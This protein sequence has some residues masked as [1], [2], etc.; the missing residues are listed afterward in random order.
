MTDQAA[1]T[2]IMVHRARPR[3]AVATAKAL[4]DQGVPL[5]LVIVDNGSSSRDVAT[6]RTEIPGAEVIELGSNTGFG[7]AANIGLRRWLNEGPGADDWAVVCPHDAVVEPHCLERLLSAARARP[8]AG[9]ASA[10]YGDVGQYG[11]FGDR[12]LPAVN[13]WFGPILETSERCLGWENADHPHGTLMILR[14]QCLDDIGLFD[15]R[16]F[17]YCEEAEL[18]LRA[19]RAGWQ[20]GVVWGAVVRN[21]GMTSER[22]VPEYLMMRNSLMLQRDHFGTRHATVLFC[23]YLFHTVRGL[24]YPSRR[25]LY[26]HTRGRLLAMADFAR[27]RSGPAPAALTGANRSTMSSHRA[28]TTLSSEP[29]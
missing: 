14:R 11:A 18:G 17:A 6:L 24:L 19:R 23:L 27:G 10:E 28:G 16:Y 26:W 5:R 12:V 7:P 3:V 9:L 2:V 25:T 29:S 22:G 4:H 21:A 13:P 8:W 15:E 20:V 1:V